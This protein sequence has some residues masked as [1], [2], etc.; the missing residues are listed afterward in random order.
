MSRAMAMVLI[1]LAMIPLLPRVAVANLGI[2]IVLVVRLVLASMT[3]RA[4]VSDLFKV[5]AAFDYVTLLA[6]R[7]ASEA[8]LAPAIPWIILM[9]LL[10]LVQ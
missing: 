9:I 5:S 10:M 7:L 2:R 3:R 6:V 4:M 1:A 8:P